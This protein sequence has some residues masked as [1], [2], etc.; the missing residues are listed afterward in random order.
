MK[1]QLLLVIS[2]LISTCGWCQEYVYVNTD[3]LILRDKPEH[4]YRVLAI[5]NAP[6]KLEIVHSDKGYDHDKAVH[7]KFYEVR[8]LYKENKRGHTIAGWVEK[9]FVVSDAKKVTVAGI[10]TAEEVNIDEVELQPYAGDAGHSPNKFNG[11]RFPPPK[12]KGGETFKTAS[13]Q[14]RV[15][16]KGKRGGCYYID[17]AGRKVYVDKGLCK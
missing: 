16:H 6:T 4:S 17:K 5:L 14:K 13:Q 10:D 12:Y 11:D 15:Y 7:Q 8:V 2:F 1:R 9:R 3:N